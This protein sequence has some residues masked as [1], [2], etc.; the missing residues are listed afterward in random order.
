MDDSTGKK[1]IDSIRNLIEK[2]GQRF[3]S[4]AY[5]LSDDKIQRNQGR[6]AALVWSQPDGQG[7]P[8]LCL[9]P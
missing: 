6:Q 1:K 4:V 3:D 7:I 2:G 8:G 5:H 9:R